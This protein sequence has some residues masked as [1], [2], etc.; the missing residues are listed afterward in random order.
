MNWTQLSPDHAKSFID[1]VKD[2]SEKV[3]FNIQLCEVYSLPIAFYEGYELVRILNRHMM[4]YLVMDYL[5]NGEDHYYLDGSES[6]FHNLNAQRALSLDENNVLSYL[7]FY[8]SYV[9]ER[10][11]SLNVVREGEEAPTQLIAHEGDVYNISAL[12]SYQ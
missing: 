11:N 5:S 4:P 10:G 2:D 9:Y 12:L 8:I 3:L 7:D 1:S 6:V